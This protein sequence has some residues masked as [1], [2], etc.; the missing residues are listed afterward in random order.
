MK[1]RLESLEKI[2][3]L[4]SK[5]HDLNKWRLAE[6]EQKRQQLE[7]TQRA[8]I[9]AIDRDAIAQGALAAAASRRLR[10]IDRQIATTKAA[11]EAQS[12]RTLDQGARAK[13][14]ER[15]VQSVDAEYRAQNERKELSDLIERSIG[16]KPSSSA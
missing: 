14:A 4:Q 13:V 12:R 1:K 7:D 6:I 3:L 2:S 15:L 5:L 11:Y 16:R 9:E 10:A 8:M